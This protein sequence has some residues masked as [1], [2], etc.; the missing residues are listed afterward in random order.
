MSEPAT[1][2]AWR[3]LLQLWPVAENG[4]DE[5]AASLVALI[6]R[7]GEPEVVDWA[8]PLL[9]GDDRELVSLAAWVLREHGF[10]QRRPFGDRVNPVL[11]DRARRQVDDSLR[12]V[13]VNALGFSEL[14]ELAAELMRYADDQSAEVRQHVAAH[15]PIMFAGDDLDD[16][17]IEVL[18]RLSRD[19][20]PHVR[21]WATM[22]LG[23]QVELDTPA[24]RDALR[25]RL[26]DEGGGAAT[27]GEAA[28]G[29]AKRKDPSVFD[30]LANWLDAEPLTVGNL[31]IDAAGELGNSVL[32]PRLIALRDAGWA[33]DPL[34]PAPSTLAWAINALQHTV[35]TGTTSQNG[36]R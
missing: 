12:A 26:G 23:S 21:D 17:A 13:L 20:D 16:A 19:A 22:G 9:A 14:P 3:Q 11:V 15:L 5:T 29:L 10:Q 18:I 35:K 8:L 7:R 4:N 1:G 6:N 28:L 25:A 34:Q 31:V 27:C 30:T 33:Q 36:D 2:D 24:I 32:L